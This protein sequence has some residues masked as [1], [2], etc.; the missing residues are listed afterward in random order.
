MSPSC[1]R[2]SGERYE[3]FSPCEIFLNSARRS[4]PELYNGQLDAAL[5]DACADGVTRES[6]G[7]VD[8]EFFHEMFAML[9]DGLDADTEFGRSFLV[10]LAFGDQLQHFH[11][12]RGLLCGLFVELSG[13]AKQ[14]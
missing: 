2:K 14:S 7:V 11:F 8:V 13:A 10:G 3:V 1:A 9:L 4:E 5:D 6:G 12:A